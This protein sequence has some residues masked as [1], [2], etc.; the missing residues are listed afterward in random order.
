[1]MPIVAHFHHGCLLARRLSWSVAGPISNPIYSFRAEW[2]NTDKSRISICLHYYISVVSVTLC[3]AYT[4]AQKDETVTKQMSNCEG[5]SLPHVEKG[6][7]CCDLKSFT[8]LIGIFNLVWIFSF[9]LYCLHVLM[10]SYLS[11]T[12]QKWYQKLIALIVLLFFFFFII[13]YG[14]LV[15]NY[16]AYNLNEY[17]FS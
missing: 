7:V 2:C 12:I 5:L 9:S 8:L 1:M 17:F 16:K 11:R 13:H 10:P 4:E 6:C 3:E 14:N 15:N